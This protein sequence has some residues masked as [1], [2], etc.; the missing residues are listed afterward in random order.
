[1]TTLTD[2]IELL[3]GSIERELDRLPVGGMLHQQIADHLFVFIATNQDGLHSG[4]RRYCV[5]CTTCEHLA[6]EATTGPVENAR[7]H[8]H[9]AEGGH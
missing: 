1:M 6:H 7:R 2:Q 5:V 9:E 4:R 8:L 3:R